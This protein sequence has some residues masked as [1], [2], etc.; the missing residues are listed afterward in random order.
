[1]SPS[2]LDLRT[3]DAEKAREF[4]E[5]VRKMLETGQSTLKGV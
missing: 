5:Q 2:S 4:S 3:D 1:M